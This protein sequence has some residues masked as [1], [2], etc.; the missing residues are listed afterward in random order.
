[1]W[2]MKMADGVQYLKQYLNNILNF[3]NTSVYEY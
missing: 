2:Q 3:R 1:M